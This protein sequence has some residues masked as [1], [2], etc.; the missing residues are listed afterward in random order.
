MHRKT[1]I[2]SWCMDLLLYPPVFLAF[3]VSSTRMTNKPLVM[4]ISSMYLVTCLVNEYNIF[5]TSCGTGSFLFHDETM[6]KPMQNFTM[7]PNGKCSRWFFETRFEHKSLFNQVQEW[8]L[9]IFRNI[10]V[11]M[12]QR[13]HVF[14]K[15]DWMSE[16]D[17]NIASA[18]VYFYGCG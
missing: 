17:M 8:I 7:K 4:P 15:P 6:L 18:G 12:T 13:L 5:Y 16:N 9:Y 3:K 2:A 10:A 11:F 14:W 1:A